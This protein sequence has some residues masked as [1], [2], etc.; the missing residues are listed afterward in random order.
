[1]PCTPGLTGIYCDAIA[2]C[3]DNAANTACK[4]AMER[5]VR[6]Q[7]SAGNGSVLLADVAVDLVVSPVVL[8]LYAGRRYA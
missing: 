4:I 1:M 2:T 3:D 5:T 7:N 6:L 8:A